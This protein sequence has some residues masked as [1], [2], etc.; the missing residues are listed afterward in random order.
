MEIILRVLVLPLALAASVV[1]CF[2]MH[3]ALMKWPRFTSQFLVLSVLGAVAVSACIVLT[4]WPGALYLSQRWPLFYGIF[5]R[6]CFV[7]GPPIAATLIISDSV[8]RKRGMVGTIVIPTAVCFGVCVV[9]L[10]GD[11]AVYEAVYGPE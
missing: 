1:F 8:K 5:Y 9:F 11:I 10:I 6:I 3:S 4:I 2:L 7:I